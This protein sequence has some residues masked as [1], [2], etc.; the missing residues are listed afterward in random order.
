MSNKIQPINTMKRIK[1]L[2]TIRQ[3]QVGG[4]ET[5][6][7]DLCTHLDKERYEPVVLSFTEGQMVDTL[8]NRG[9]R[10]EVINTEKPF[11]YKVWRKV[12]NFMKSEKFDLIHAHGT[13]AM[14]NVFCPSKI[15]GLPLIY[16]IHGWSFHMNQ[17]HI[18][19]RIR[20]LS[21]KF[22]TNM[23]DKN[24][25]VS[26]SNEK[27]GIQKFGM[28]R[29]T[30]IYNSVD[31]DKFNPINSF[32]D[33]RKELG[34]GSEKIVIGYFVRITAQK[35]PF[36][37]L[38][39]MKLV[40]E[41]NS[42]VMLL[43]IGDGDLK[44]ATI[45]LAKSLKI[46]DHVIFQPFRSDIPDALNAI[47][48]YCLPS[49]WEG[50]PIGILEAMAM[51]KAIVASPVDG[52]VE[53]IDDGDTGILVPNSEPLKLADILL[54]LSKDQQLRDAIAINAYQQVRS[55]F[56]IDR[57]IKQISDVYMGIAS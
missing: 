1:I 53:M 12:H 51:Q 38:K 18:V 29:S 15:L 17:K 47:D 45:E 21:E 31:F 13:R 9:I 30:V 54:K 37:M 48:I 49:L 22:I 42:N 36:T 56:G 5:H 2:E 41:E 11:D 14:S 26:R 27:D 4:G 20:E 25:C 40:V 35:D 8:R 6:V 52:T 16:T 19:R 34:I 46:E 50:F 39:A 55:R 33:I 57:M 24:I 10:T 28:K 23:A 44:E 3:G 7:L 43:M 32:K